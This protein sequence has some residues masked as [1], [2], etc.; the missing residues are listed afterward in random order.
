[1]AYRGFIYESEEI[2][3]TIEV[4]GRVRPTKNN[5]GNPIHATLNGIVAFWRW[6][7]DSK[8]VDV[9]GNPLVLY[10]GSYEDF[11]EFQ[12]PWD[13]EDYDPDENYQDGYAGGN[14]GIGFYFT[15][16][17]KYAETFG[18]T[19][20][21]YLK[22]ENLFDLTTEANQEMVNTR[23]QEER[24]ELDYGEYGEVIDE[25]MKEDRYD[26]A[27][28]EGVGGLS[29][30]ADEWKVVDGRQAKA[31]MNSGTF[32]TASAKVTVESTG[33]AFPETIN[34]NGKVRP[35]RNSAGSKIYSTLEGIVNF[36]KWFGDSNTV[37]QD[38]RP[39]LYFHG[40]ARTGIGEFSGDRGFAGH[41]TTDTKMAEDFANSR[42][43]DAINS[44]TD[45]EFGDAATIYP[46]YLKCLNTFN[47]YNRDD[48]TAIK[49][50]EDEFNF[51]YEDVELFAKDIKAA[52]YDSALDFEHGNNEVTGI[53][54]FNANQ[55]KS[56]T[57]NNGQFSDSP[58]ITHESTL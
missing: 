28:G 17:R 46:V 11:E 43:I 25:I 41:F 21:Y 51:G 47:I 18:R 31:V 27:Y 39:I 14:L 45:V 7:G 54:V 49:L 9:N 44:G 30:G 42:H 13:R 6:F 20:E 15:S 33:T 12:L 2:P 32:S 22:I 56:A 24:D 35:T 3:E 1:M 38:G 52:G 8:A 55:I 36:W 34:V 10:H 29:Y 5:K 26:A 23:F 40:T 58:S 37:T 4:D 48:R 16:H 57:G 19:K 53:A 50:V